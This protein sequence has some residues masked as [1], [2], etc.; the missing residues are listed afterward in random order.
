MALEKI[1]LEDE[2]FVS[3]KL[4]PNVDFYSGIVQRAHRHPGVAVHRDLRAGAHR[5]LDRAVE[6]DDRRSGVQDR[7][8]APALHR[9]DA[10]A[11]SSR[12]TS[13][14]SGQAAHGEHNEGV[15]RQLVP[16]RRQRAVHRG[17]VRALPRQPGVGARRV[18][19]LLRPLQ[20]V[21]GSSA[22]DVAH[23]PVVES[24]VA[25]RKERRAGAARTLPPSASRPSAS[26]SRCCC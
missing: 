11:T 10:S 22:K 8:A 2:Y 23:A 18:A 19:R 16:V 12:S 20:Q 14:K 26:R 24:F 1:A 13:A 3:R 5:R 7:P 6:R 4:Y 25:A 17:A 15:P 9:R 21:P